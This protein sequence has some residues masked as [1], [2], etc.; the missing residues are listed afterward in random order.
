MVQN[1]LV[2]VALAF[3]EHMREKATEMLAKLEQV[4]NAHRLSCL[5]NI[6]GWNYQVEARTFTA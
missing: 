2:V 1:V 5:W 3:D 6:R 4:K